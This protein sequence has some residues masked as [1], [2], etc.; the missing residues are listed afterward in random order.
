MPRI[1]F[2]LAGIL[3]L[4]LAARTAHAQPGWSLAAP[5]PPAVVFVVNGS[6]D[7]TSV[8]DNL[9]VIIDARCLP[10]RAHTVRW[11][12]WMSLRKDHVDFGA[13]LVAA[14]KL[15]AQITAYRAF[16]PR[17]P[18]YVIGHSAGCHVILA[19]TRLLP[20]G[21]VDRIILLAPSVSQCHDL[22]PALRCSRDGLVVFWSSEDG[23]LALGS[24]WLGNADRLPGQSAGLTGFAFPAPTFPDAQLYRNLRQY[25]WC[26]AL[27][28]TGH[29]GRHYGWTRVPFLDAYVVPLLFN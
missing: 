24:E 17:E 5:Q 3:G 25:A 20:P 4:M 9:R 21:A 12:R 7:D 10:L 27:A 11:C 1:C 13:Q 22:R 2:R 29:D 28:W 14:D 16:F 19:A 26:P 15:A 18:I 8:S 6:A 23:L